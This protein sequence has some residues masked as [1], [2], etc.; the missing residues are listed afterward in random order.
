M[1]ESESETAKR[2]A[3]VNSAL[4]TF[5]GTSA[6]PLWQSHFF[7]ESR[8][9]QLLV[10]TTEKF[11]SE[12][13]NKFTEDLAATT[14]D[15]NEVEAFNEYEFASGHHFTLEHELPRILRY[16]L[17][18]Q[19]CSLLEFTLQE[20]AECLH[21]ERNLP[22]SPKDLTGR[23][24]QQ[25]RKYLIKVAQVP[26]PE[27]GACW[28]D[29]SAVSE[30]RNVVVHKNG[31]LMDDSKRTAKTQDFIKKHAACVHKDETGRFCFTHEFLPLVVGLYQE[32]MQDLFRCFYAPTPPSS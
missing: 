13:F 32:F 31:F 22:L 3:G 6:L 29:I 19:A 15:M 8:Q 16:S 21:R 25:A 11:L 7:E 10:E 12:Q 1:G 18:V 30:I 26:L 9:L 17:L 24:I 20:I 14:K 23:G 5:L 28:E 4:G 27:Q 2:N